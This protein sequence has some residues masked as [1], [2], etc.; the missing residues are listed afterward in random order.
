MVLLRVR[1]TK[2]TA[3]VNVE[4]AAS[5]ADLWAVLEAPPHSHSKRSSVLATDPKGTATLT[6]DSASIADLGLSHGDMIY[7]VE[8]EAEPEPLPSTAQ[9]TPP[10]PAA[11]A[12]R[13]AAAAAFP[14]QQ[15]QQQ[16]QDV[17]APLHEQW[18]DAYSSSDSAVAQQLAQ[19]DAAG[20]PDDEMV[21]ALAAAGLNPD[22][23]P[24]LRQADSRRFS[25]LLGGHHSD[26]D[27]GDDLGG[28]AGP[29]LPGSRRAPPRDFMAQLQ[30]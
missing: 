7:V 10:E 26:D 15:Q 18:S 21:A 3:R 13:H 17:R 8:K 30:R 28:A 27:E 12:A 9:S 1:S 4:P 20:G 25:T 11:A 5:L 23:T 16:Q 19:E 24:M 29:R 22:G 14:Q 2:G 6:S